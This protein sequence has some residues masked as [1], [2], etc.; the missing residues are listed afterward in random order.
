[1]AADEIVLR[2]QVD[3]RVVCRTGPGEGEDAWS[4]GTVVKLWHREP[5]WP[6]R[7]VA[8]YQVRL[9]T[10]TLIFAP[11]DDDR[12]I[13][14]LS[15]LLLDGKLPVTILTGFLGAGK[16]TLLNYILTRNHGKKFAVIENEVGAIGIDNQLLKGG[17]DKASTTEQ[18]TLL[19]NGCLCCTV[20]GDLVDAIKGIVETATKKQKELGDEA[21]RALDG[22][23][24][25]TTGVADPG[26]ICKTF[27]GDPFCTAYCKIDGVITVVDGVNFVTQLTRERSEGSVN[28]S[29]QQVAFADKILLNK[30]DAVSPEKLQTVM[31]AIRGVNEFVPITQ[32]ALAKSPDLDIA[33]LVSINA[34]DLTKMVDT[35]HFDLS[36]CGAVTVGAEATPSAPEPEQ[37]HGHGHGHESHGDGHGHGH[38]GDCAPD[39]A[40]D[41]GGHGHGGDHAGHGGGHAAG[42]AH[43]H[44]AAFRHDSG[45]SSFVCQ[46]N[47]KAI[48]F[49]KFGDFMH[50][51]LEKSE[52][53]YRYK[54]ILAMQDPRTKKIVRKVI[55]GVHD[56]TEMEHGEE[57]PADQPVKSQFVVI[58]RNLEKDKTQAEFAKISM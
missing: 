47:D 25:E 13:K 20:R 7:K 46:L 53:L 51:L 29:A 23:L 34:F 44:S 40:D 18:I 55:Q 54:G 6:K 33:E 30:V 57:W 45:V 32:C 31:E 11:M 14:P 2:F 43:G 39:C 17:Y 5:G 22:I 8:P 49:H 36:V 12:V 41:H 26:P 58:G 4:A 52:N 38:G 16:T 48:D 50:S 37:G 27:Y 3:D 24:I 10:G 19:D 28:E 1:M 15:G 56:M 42:H 21:G 9:D 35:T